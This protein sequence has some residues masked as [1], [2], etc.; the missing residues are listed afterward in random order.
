MP[1][2]QPSTLRSIFH[3]DGIITGLRIRL[4]QVIERSGRCVLLAD[5]AAE[6]RVHVLVCIEHDAF[7]NLV[8]RCPLWKPLDGDGKRD[9]IVRVVLVH[10]LLEDVIGNLGEGTRLAGECLGE[11]SGAICIAELAALLDFLTRCPKADLVALP[12]LDLQIPSAVERGVFD[13]VA[14]DEDGGAPR[15]LDDP[16]GTVVDEVFC[17]LF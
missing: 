6:T 13:G 7:R 3:L 12:D 5:S 4:R 1:H 15:L 10:D 2:R 17:G 11:T 14:V 16:G 8:I 9:Q